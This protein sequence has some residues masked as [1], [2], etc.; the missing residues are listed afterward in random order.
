[1]CG[2]SALA[3]CVTLSALAWA[4]VPTGAEII[5]VTS[6]SGGTGG[7]GCT[8]RDAITAANTDTPTGGC[9]A[10]NGVDTIELP[11]DVTITLTAVDNT[12]TGENGLPVVASAITINGNGA[13]IERFLFG[14]LWMMGDQQ[15][16]I[17]L[18]CVGQLRPGHAP[19]RNRIGSGLPFLGRLLIKIR[20][21]LEQLADEP[22][23]TD[24]QWPAEH[25]FRD[26]RV[27]RDR[28]QIPPA[29]IEHGVFLPLLPERD[30]LLPCLLNVHFSPSR[31]P[32]A[33]V[34]LCT[35]YRKDQHAALTRLCP[36][37]SYGE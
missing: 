27:V 11:V 7:P 16:K 15:S 35:L 6:D 22:A 24:I 1:M 4:V 32:L 23:Q 2:R 28:R 8:L 18:V 25:Q 34:A 13:T 9:P 17:R 37:V 29:D 14:H 12:T 3:W 26:L 31:R 10:G 20:A 19:H 33:E 5:I 36:R 30:N 21:E